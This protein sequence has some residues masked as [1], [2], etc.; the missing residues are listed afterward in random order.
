ISDGE[1]HRGEMVTNSEKGRIPIEITASPLRDATGA[2]VGGI[3]IIRDISTRRQAEVVLQEHQQK[4]E[5][6]LKYSQAL[7]HMAETVIT[8]EDHEVI[9][10]SM[11]KTVGLTLGLGCARIYRLYE[12][13][14]SFSLI[15]EWLNQESDTVGN[16]TPYLDLDRLTGLPATPGKEWGECHEGASLLW[17]PFGHQPVGNFV[18]VIQMHSI[19]E[20]QEEEITFLASVTK[21]VE[22]ALQ[23]INYLTELRQN[24]ELLQMQ[25][26]AMN[27]TADGMALIGIDEI[28]VYVNAALARLFGCQEQELLTR[29]WRELFARKELKRFDQEILPEFSENGHW[30]GEVVGQKT[31]GS[32][33]FL[34]LS[35]DSIQNVGMVWVL[36]D[37]TEQK[38]MVHQL[39]HQAHHDALTALPNRLL[40]HERLEL[41]LKRAKRKK[42]VLAVLFLDLDRFKLVND[43]MGHAIGDE[44]LKE[45]TQRLVGCVRESDTIARM[46]GDEFTLLLPEISSV[47]DAE[48]VANKILATMQKPWKYANQEFQVT[49]SIGIA[50]Y[51]A[52]GTEIETLL[53]HADIAMYRAKEVGRNNYVIYDQSMDSEVLERLAIENNL[54]HAVE[55]EE[56]VLHYQP[57]VNTR[58]REIIGVEALL[59]WKPRGKELIMPGQFIP[60]AEE[61]GLIVPIGEWVLRTA[62]RQNK[63]WQ[64]AGFPPFI[65]TVNL[66]ARQFRQKNL[67]ETVIGI[68]K[69]TGLDA[70]WLEL[71]IT[72]SVAMQDV[73]STIGTLRQLDELGVKLAIDDFGTGYS[74]LNYIKHFPIHTLKIDRSFVGD[75]PGNS[76]NAAVV[77]TIIVLAQNLNLKVI[78]EGV[79]TREQC[80]FLQE[81]NCVNM[82]GYLFA[83]PVPV[84]ELEQMLKLPVGLK[85]NTVLAGDKAI[86]L[87]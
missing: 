72:E 57:Q 37:I 34:E 73:E 22:L 82:Q 19:R 78:G 44:L 5:L 85:V 66:S 30:H 2:I 59:R 14:N 65:V 38:E 71:E 13:D 18:I 56:L 10:N 54:R 76:S 27:S 48:I 63:A 20:W 12:E 51:P 3:E 81:R 55:R 21:H 24:S 69:D 15:S 74:S 64:D 46:G 8:S 83:R 61:T 39:I 58:T 52:D 41:E 17:Y 36:R 9:L 79:E 80:E 84:T 28:P 32:Q 31:D 42:Q 26:A 25:S 29:T 86:E 60:I 77:S 62:C 16:S 45:V 49:T 87:A 6:Q 23:K 7:T 40:F 75:I 67:V 43:M 4:Q 33:F 70:R 68:L 53:K 1:I 47:Q 11:C 35:M 50:T